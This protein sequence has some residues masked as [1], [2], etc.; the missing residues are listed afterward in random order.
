MTRARLYTL[1]G[2][3]CLMGYGWLFYNI[4]QATRGGFSPCL[5]RAITGFP[6]PAC[7][8][9]RSIVAVLRGEMQ[10]AL[11]LNPL[12]FLGIAL[13]IV[14]P[15]WLISDLVRGSDSL[16]RFYLKAEA[17]VRRKPVALTLLALLLANWLWNLTKL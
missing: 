14:I 3:A 11:L 12:G 13:L 4:T 8:S 10:E 17:F 7:G 2:I 6:C 5:F 15:L 16:L 9:T 1:A